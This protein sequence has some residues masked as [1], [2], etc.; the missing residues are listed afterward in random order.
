MLTENEYVKIKLYDKSK[1][2]ES[3]NK[4]LGYNEPERIA[5]EGEGLT[6]LQIGKASDK[7]EV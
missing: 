3:I 2:I 7:K 4:M 5:L 1:A 6:P